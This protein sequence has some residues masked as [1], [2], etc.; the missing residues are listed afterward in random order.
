MKLDLADLKQLFD[1]IEQ[2]GIDRTLDEGYLS[3][4]E[5]DHVLYNMLKKYWDLNKQIQDY[6]QRA[7]EQ[8]E[9]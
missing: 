3:F 6:V 9:I 8:Y 7:R 5:S 4:A 2:Q 1:S